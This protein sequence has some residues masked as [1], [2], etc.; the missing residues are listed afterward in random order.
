MNS[1]NELT[2][3]FSSSQN[4]RLLTVGGGRFPAHATREPLSLDIPAPDSSDSYLFA[5]CS[6]QS[7]GTSRVD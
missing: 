5:V 2:N 3:L 7:R 6:L 1:A 4:D